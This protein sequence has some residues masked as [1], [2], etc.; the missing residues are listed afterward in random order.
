MVI[1]VPVL[2]LSR[3]ILLHDSIFDNNYPM[4]VTR[5]GDGRF[6]III[7]VPGWLDWIVDYVGV[8]LIVIISGNKFRLAQR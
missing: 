3:E 4:I 8:D 7:Y 6:I 1:F 2:R 5:L